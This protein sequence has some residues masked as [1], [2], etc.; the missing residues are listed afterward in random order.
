M[1]VARKSLPLI[2]ILFLKH[3][4]E[5]LLHSLKTRTIKLGSGYEKRTD[6][7]FLQQHSPLKM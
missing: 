2:N 3:I 5:D 4:S 1:L 6:A 7:T